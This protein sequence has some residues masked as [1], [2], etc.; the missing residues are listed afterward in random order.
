MAGLCPGC[1][2]R[3][4][5]AWSKPRCDCGLRLLDV[6]DE[7]V[8]AVKRLIKLGFEV[9]GAH[10][11]TLENRHGNGKHT[12][13]YIEFNS[14]YP[15]SIFYQL[16][17]DWKLIAFRRELGDNKV[18][19]FSILTGKCEYPPNKCDDE[20]IKLDMEA[21][22]SNLETWLKG[23]DPELIKALLLLSGCG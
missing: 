10:H 8:R 20:S 4:K 6:S 9:Y 3:Y 22:I 16:P 2:R 14:L 19:E 1:L 23:K 15:D 13:I 21:T 11:V 12:G 7:L 17:P 5:Y 18:L